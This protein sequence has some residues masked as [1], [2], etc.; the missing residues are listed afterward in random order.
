[1]MIRMR[2]LVLIVP[3]VMLV[4][5]ARLH[6]A[7]VATLDVDARD[8]PRGI[9]RV[10]LTLP[11]RP[12]DLTLLFPEWLPGEHSPDG[13]INGLS[14]LK[15][16]ANGTT[17]AWRRDPVNMYAFHLSVP[18]GA[19]TLEVMFAID[20][21]AHAG[22][23]NAQRTVTE[24]MGVLLWN[25]LVLYPA[26]VPSDALQYKARLRLPAGWQF[27]T[28]LPPVGSQGDTTEFAAVS[29]TTLVDSTL[30]AGRYFRTVDLG[31]TPAVHLHLA[32]DSEAALD[33]PTATS[34]A[35]KKL[36]QQ[37][38]ALFGATHYGEYHFL[39]ALSDQLGFE[40]IE[41]HQSSD[42]RTPERALVDESLRKS[43]SVTTLLPHE[44]VH[45][46]NGKFR[47]PA[48]LATGNYDAPMRGELLW[49]YEGLTEYLGMVLSARSGLASAEE[50]RDA[51]ADLAGFLE[52]AK[53]RDWR[54][55]ADTATAA[56]ISY[57]EAREWRPQTRSASDFYEESA[58]LWLEADVLIRER[59]HGAKS[60]DDFC[61]LFFGPPSTAPKVEPYGFD[62]VVRA[63]NTVWPYDWR[64]YWTERLNRV[65]PK[66]PLDGILA[67]G[68]RLGFAAEPSAE[69][70]GDLAAVKRS[71]FT[72]SLGFDLADEGSSITSLV[73]GSP[74]DTAGIAPDSVLVAVNGRKYGKDVIDDALKSTAQTERSINLLIEKD[75]M[76]RTFEI[77]YR[78]GPRYPR[79]E[80][81]E[82]K[83]DYLNAILSPR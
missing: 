43:S 27:G 49:V 62:D 54:P 46:W 66:A 16:S 42:N 30:L 65:S 3:L 80:R 12:G 18:S 28:A 47:R 60:L 79:L 72:F 32:A 82:S 33:L 45:S 20:A 53:G 74:A 56:P 57:S 51:W 22:E 15:F 69:Q 34:D 58:M 21:V 1:M 7:P 8:A 13:P 73:P 25:Q 78:G 4:A 76:F 68:W 29:L 75:E 83:T 41:H 17:L 36:V 61:R 23:K 63:L 11:V 5:A 9:E 81:D 59:S 50:A 2:P 38:T 24:N 31:G 67:A 52:R 48:G 14:D 19:S 64:G 71:S 70:K 40:G 39:W 10:H 37:A 26:G 44:Y 55:L 35:L 77:R 6:A